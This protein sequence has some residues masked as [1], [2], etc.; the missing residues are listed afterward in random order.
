MLYIAQ[1]RKYLPVRPG[2][3][4]LMRKSVVAALGLALCGAAGLIV[5]QR[6]PAGDDAATLA[7]VRSMSDRLSHEPSV[8]A[9]ATDE[10][11]AAIESAAQ[12]AAFPTSAPRPDA[13]G[14]ADCIATFIA[15]R[16]RADAEGYIRWKTE[17]GWRI[18][19]DDPKA[20]RLDVGYRY[21]T[22]RELPPDA[23][24][25][26]IFEALFTGELS[27]SRGL[28]R[29]QRAS[30][31]P[32]SLIVDFARESDPDKAMHALERL[33]PLDQLWGGAIS[34][35]GRPHWDPPQSP[36]SIAA[37]SGP[38]TWARVAIGCKGTAGVWF[39]MRL[40]AFYDTTAAQWRLNQV[41]IN[42]V[43]GDDF[44]GIEH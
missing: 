40:T 26:H 8:D 43:A 15:L 12:R 27:H 19:S 24:R 6:R 13:A 44:L 30:A 36:E 1:R 18:R 7:M 4:L 17:E 41:T 20:A 31:G 38:L 28:Q 42:N 14:L 3:G 10:L 5:W 39:P 29:P 32:L 34:Y 11:R 23:D 33:H 25:T 21:L 35:G 22:G 2:D 37:S 16:A 9:T